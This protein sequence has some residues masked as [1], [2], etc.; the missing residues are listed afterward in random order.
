MT[1]KTKFHFFVHILI[2][3]VVN[4]PGCV[5]KPPMKG[6]HGGAPVVPVPREA[7]VEGIP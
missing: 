1:D 6:R 4:H 2:A 5:F 7:E 3:T